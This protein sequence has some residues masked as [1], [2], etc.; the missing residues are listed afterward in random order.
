MVRVRKEAKNNGKNADY[1]Q[2][3]DVGVG[4]NKHKEGQDANSAT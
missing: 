1:A 3:R 4:R 2:H